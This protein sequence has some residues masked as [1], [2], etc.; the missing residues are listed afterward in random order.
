MIRPWLFRIF[1]RTVCLE[2]VVPLFI[3]FEEVEGAAP[4]T[5]AGLAMP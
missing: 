4:I 1:T 2:F 3:Q 5:P